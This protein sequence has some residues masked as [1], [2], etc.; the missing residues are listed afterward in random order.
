MRQVLYLFDIVGREEPV[1][2]WGQHLGQKGG[3]VKAQMAVH[4]EQ[5]H[6]QNGRAMTLEGVNGITSWQL[7][8]CSAV[9][10]YSMVLTI[11]SMD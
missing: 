4:R 8:R 7:T 10:V 11:W 1:S 2:C 6:L 9:F 5:W 3:G